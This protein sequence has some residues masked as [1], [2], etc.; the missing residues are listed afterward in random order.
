MLRYTMYKEDLRAP[1]LS[2]SYTA[3]LLPGLHE[4]TRGFYQRQQTAVYGPPHS[5]AQGRTSRR[6]W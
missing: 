3:T 1:T 6:P 5:I 4:N 2:E